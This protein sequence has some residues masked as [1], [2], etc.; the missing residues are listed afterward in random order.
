LSAL[1]LAAER[2]CDE[3][4]AARL[5]DR[6]Q[7][8]DAILKVERLLQAAGACVT[9]LSATFG[10]DTVP[11]RVSAL[12]VA[13]KRSGNG[14]LLVAAFASISCAVLAASGPLHHFTESL[15]EALVH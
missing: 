7:V 8:A 1:E 10:G 15:L 3:V 12:L 14:V 9:P 6:L 5:G 4:A 2:S 11:Q 13:P